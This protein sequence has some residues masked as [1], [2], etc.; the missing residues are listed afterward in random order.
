MFLFYHVVFI[1]TES[2]Y[3]LALLEAD[4]DTW[5]KEF[6]WISPLVGKLEVKF[7]VKGIEVKL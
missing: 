3:L 2:S 1:L 4:K 6:V 5:M 7:G